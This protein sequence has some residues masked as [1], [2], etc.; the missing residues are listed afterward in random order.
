VRCRLIALTFYSEHTIYLSPPHGV[1][2]SL[3]LYLKIHD[4]R[5]SALDG[6]VL[7]VVV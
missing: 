1:M 2:L 5:Y 6:G 4:G 3:L 7:H